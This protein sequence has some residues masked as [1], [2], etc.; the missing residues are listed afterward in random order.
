MDSV[1]QRELNDGEHRAPSPWRPRTK[2]T[3]NIADDAINSLNLI[4]GLR[5]IRCGH[6]QSRTKDRE[7][8]SLKFA[9]KARVAIRDD[10]QWQPLLTKHTIDKSIAVPLPSIKPG[11]A[12][13]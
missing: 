2:T 3:K 12:A 5:M 1:F 10:F 9:G 4:I 11:S 13:E 8:G 7:G 6:V